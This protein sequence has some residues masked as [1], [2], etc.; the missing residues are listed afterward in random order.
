LDK[1]EFL[2]KDSERAFNDVRRYSHELR[3]G[4][5]EHLGLQA[6]LEQIA[7][8]I[9]KLKQVPVELHVEG[10]EPELS[11]EVKL[12]FF[13]ITQEALNNARKHAKASQLSI[14]LSFKPHLVRMV[15]SDDGMGFSSRGSS[16]ES[17]SRGSLGLMSMR[18]RANLINGNL[19][20]E[21]EPGKGTKVILKARV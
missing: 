1:L 11:E 17:L 13:R 15:I 21:S 9:N 16:K 10:N 19:Q 3:P 2:R 8:D 12:A 14:D 4:V 6:A 7:D 20:I 5:L 18:E